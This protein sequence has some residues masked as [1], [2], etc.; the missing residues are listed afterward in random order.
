MFAR[1]SI[2]AFAAVATLGA[3][4]LTTTSASAFGGFHGGGFH[5]GFHGG[6]RGFRPHFVHFRPHFYPSYRF[7]WRRPVIYSTPVVSTVGYSV[8]QPS[9][10]SC[11][12]KEYTADGNVLFKDLCTKESALAPTQEAMAQQQ[13]QQLPQQNPPQQN[14]PR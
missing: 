4:A 10:C 12:T 13:D 7:G 1:T 6:F 5:G 14:Q 9:R 2:L 3:A 8:A 11:L